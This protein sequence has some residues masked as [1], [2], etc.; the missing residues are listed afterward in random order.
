MFVIQSLLCI[1][2][3]R[4]KLYATELVRKYFSLD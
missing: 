1:F 3:M 2:V 4:M